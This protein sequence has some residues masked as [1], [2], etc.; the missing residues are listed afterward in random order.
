MTALSNGKRTRPGDRQ[1]TTYAQLQRLGDAQD[2]RPSHPDRQLSR[3]RKVFDFGDRCG[4]SLGQ[5]RPP[6]RR[7]GQYRCNGES[8]GVGTEG[9]HN[10]L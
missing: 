1:P 7:K 5:C 6:P 3:G 2:G 8:D 4:Q 9:I 10:D